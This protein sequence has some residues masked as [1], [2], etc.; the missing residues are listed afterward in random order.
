ML[1]TYA[2]IGLVFIG[3]VVLCVVTM[4]YFMAKQA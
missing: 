1:A 4:V 3:V 2:G